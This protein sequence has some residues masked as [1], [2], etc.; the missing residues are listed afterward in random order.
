MKILD[1]RLLTEKEAMAWLSI[2][3]VQ[4]WKLV[5]QG[6]IPR[7]S[8]GK[9]SKRYCKKDLIKYV[10]DNRGIGTAGLGTTTMGHQGLTNKKKS[11]S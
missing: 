4:L 2:G 9:K 5:K 6:L 7:I 10:N 3:K 1:D 11:T 8:I